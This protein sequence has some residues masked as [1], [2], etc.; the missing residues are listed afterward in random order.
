[1]LQ[2]TLID[3]CYSAL[4][5]KWGTIRSSLGNSNTTSDPTEGPLA[6]LLL[7]NILYS[8][9][10]SYCN[11]I[12]NRL[13]CTIGW[14]DL[15]IIAIFERQP[16]SADQVYFRNSIPKKSVNFAHGTCGKLFIKKT[17]GPLSLIFFLKFCRNVP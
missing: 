12:L 7:R 17:Q 13:Y 15:A 8:S 16:S 11:Y 5:L 14:S 6:P 1:M 2:R 4:L 10:C 3:P 9:T